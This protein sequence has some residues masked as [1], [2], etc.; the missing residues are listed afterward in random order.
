M[1]E[2]VPRLDLRKDHWEI[3]R[4]LL[5]EHVPDRKVIAFG[6]R[7]TWEAKEYSDLDLALLGDDP[8]SPTVISALSE[9]LMESDLPFKV[10]LVCWTQID[11]KL[12]AAILRDGIAVQNSGTSQALPS[13][14]WNKVRIGDI[15]N[16]VGGG[17]PSTKDDQNFDG[18][19]PWLTPKDLSKNHNRYIE[20][21]ERYLSQ[22]GLAK[23]SARLLP[24]GA[25]LLTTRAPIGYTAIAKNPI[26]TNQGF[27]NLVARDGTLPEYLYYWLTQN[28][29]ELKRHA[30]GSTFG[31]LAG[32]SLKDIE[33]S[34]PPLEE[35]RWITH[36]LG[37]LD[38]KIELNQRMNETLEAIARS[39]FKDWFVDFGPV[40]A[41]MVGK[42]P[43]LQTDLWALFPN[44]LSNRKIPSNWQI[45]RLGE[46]FE[47]TMGQS[48]R[49]SSYNET[50][51][52]LPFFQGS[53]DFGFRYAFHR[54]FCN[55]PLRVAQTN[56]TLVS[57]RAPVG[58]INMAWE[59]CCIGRGVASLRHHSCSHSY[60]YY[61]IKALSRD[62]AH[63]EDNGT[64][65]GA[66]TGKQFKNLDILE[67]DLK[68][69]IAFDKIIRP[70]DQRI[71][72]NVAQSRNLTHIREAL[73]PKLI[74][75]EIRMNDPNG[76]RGE[77]P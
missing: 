62:I 1:S 57:V 68:V 16:V 52:G 69:V 47:L 64:V 51:D 22:Q 36:I 9:D 10:D 17:T 65:F 30:S 11:Q 27:R 76:F 7:S 28:T 46:C 43:Y 13:A 4:N 59:K 41:K 61:A 3:V 31:E 35:Q 21:G 39:I 66:I 29:D 37:T 20:S 73:L 38:D 50:G 77:E 49:G 56:D 2:I 54:R 32:S 48:P 74:S 42:E 26:A 18:K 58:D 44:R 25:V 60:T 24:T 15:A 67:P 70:L 71:K 53:K 63:F 12:R 8:V 34:L 40:R 19:I 23:S 14:H 55:L 72:L 45:N 33:L 6:S 5:Q 75:G